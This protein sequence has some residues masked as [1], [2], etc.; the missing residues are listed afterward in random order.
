P[1]IQQGIAFCQAALE[2][3]SS[4]RYVLP[5]LIDL[6][7]RDASVNR[8]KEVY[9]LL[10]DYV[11]NSSDLEVCAAAAEY[12]LDRL[13][14]REERERLL[15]ELL[16]DLG[17]RN[18]IF[19][20]E[21][22]TVLGVLMAEKSNLEA[23]GFYFAQ[24][25]KNNKYNKTAFTRL[26]ELFPDKLGPELYLEH[27]RLAV[28]ENPTN[29]D[30]AVDLAGYAE[31]LELYD[32][33]A[34]M[35]EYC[36][37][38]FAYLY[39][40]ENLPSNIYIPWAISA[41][42]TKTNQHKCLRIAQMVRQTGRFDLLLEGLAGKAAAKM[43]DGLQ[44]T[45]IFQA[46]EQKINM[47]LDKGPQQSTAKATNRITAKQA[48]WFYGLVLPNPEKAMNWANIAYSSE[49]NSPSTA[50]LLAYALVMNDRAK[51]A[52]PLLKNYPPNQ[53]SDLVRAQIQVQEGDNQ[54]AISTLK[55]VIAKDPG[56]VAAETA[57]DLLGKLGG[58][59][60]PPADPDIIMDALTRL[61]GQNFI[62]KLTLPE[63]ILSV[64][65]NMRGNKFPYGSDFG[66]VVS[67][68]NNGS[69]PLVLSEEGLFRGGLRI[70]AKV[71]GDLEAD[72]PNLVLKK[73]RTGY[74]VQSGKSLLI[75]V[76]L[77][78]GDLRK[79]LLSHPQ[80]SLDVEFTL[81]LDP[82]IDQ[83]GQ[84]RNRLNK[85]PLTRTIVTRPGIELSG[86]YLRNRFTL[87]STGQSGQKI[88]TAQLFVGL[89]AEQYAMSNRTPPYKFMYADWMPTLFRNALIHE[90]GLLLNPSNG[91]WVV[92]VHTMAQMILLPMDH[93]LVNAVSENLNNSNWPVRLMACYLLAKAQTG[94]FTKVLEW[95]AEYDP[96]PIV[97]DMAGAL[98]SDKSR[99]EEGQVTQVASPTK[100][101]VSPIE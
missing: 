16:G 87:I 80:A 101:A 47:F 55:A 8:S 11:D 25:Y 45:Q 9:R 68:G 53:I 49:P 46:A 5:L 23:A 89:L 27:L 26:A 41:Y 93:S 35:Y 64:Q 70:D 39:P 6:S 59:Y 88:K 3:D 100:F 54:Q 28:R 15:E 30:A 90:S 18:V 96:S 29:L 82:V 17:N 75:P 73:V 86:K 42:N 60:L 67:I 94:D 95:A 56:S 4:A 62:P 52:Q 66:G 7:C 58:Q 61:F 69:E 2:L 92:K 34:D 72:I 91:E 63:K 43:G 21:L 24:A 65:F 98:A 36:A 85:L 77:V 40:S 37:G 20:S 44:A 19:G 32:I 99:M 31:R 48:A 38:L 1:K 83:N 51:W 50:S 79:I 76:E 74:L 22:A 78:T 84:V 57:K 33:A 71:S 81:Y 12:L 10:I 14:S 97:R 13:N